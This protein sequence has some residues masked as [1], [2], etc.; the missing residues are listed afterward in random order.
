MFKK[1]P[2]RIALEKDREF[3]LW[4]FDS[5]CVR[6]GLPTGVIHEV[7]PISHG[8]SSLVW[9]NRVPV[10][11]ACHEWAHAIGTNK[12]IPILQAKRKEYLVRRFEL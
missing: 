12:S 6:C 5:R 10:C 2:A 7:I 9:R 1:S 3:I 4:L 8:K 11:T